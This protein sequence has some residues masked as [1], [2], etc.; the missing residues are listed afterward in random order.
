MSPNEEFSN[1]DKLHKHVNLNRPKPGTTTIIIITITLFFLYNAPGY[2]PLWV[3]IN[4]HCCN[5]IPCS[6]WLKQQKLISHSSRD[7]S[8]RIMEVPAWSGSGE[9]P[10]PDL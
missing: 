10:V 3:F 5:R 8:L 2:Q 1:E 6:G 4:S 7:G 9:S